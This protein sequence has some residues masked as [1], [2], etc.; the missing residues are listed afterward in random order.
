MGD[1]WPLP[2]SQ[3]LVASLPVPFGTSIGKYSYSFDVSRTPRVTPGTGGSVTVKAS[4]GKVA[5]VFEVRLTFGR[6]GYQGGAL[7][8]HARPR[9]N[10][11]RWESP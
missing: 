3:L 8:W 9:T 1:V 5:G 6:I 4:D 7:G 11:G 2:V 10:T